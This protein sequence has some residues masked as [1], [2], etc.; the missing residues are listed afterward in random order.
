MAFRESSTSSTHFLQFSL[1]TTCEP[2]A[3]QQAHEKKSALV[4][5]VAIFATATCLLPRLSHFL[6]SSP[7][8]ALPSV[9]V[10]FQGHSFSPAGLLT[11]CLHRS[12]LGLLII[13]TE[14]KSWPIIRTLQKRVD[15]YFHLLSVSYLL[16]PCRPHCTP[17]CRALSCVLKLS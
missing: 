4:T 16:F 3:L 9:L 17:Q 7:F 6:H 15:V 5:G 11:C 8:S 2:F 10:A 13:L 1:Y 14:L 12:F